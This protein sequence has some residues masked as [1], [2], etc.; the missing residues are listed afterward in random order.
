MPVPI[1]P[2]A[3]RRCGGFSRIVPLLLSSLVL[4]FAPASAATA[5]SVPAGQGVTAQSTT[6]HIAEASRRFAIP[7]SWIRA[8]LRA[9]SAGDMRAVS[10]AGAIGLMQIMPD[11]WAELRLRYGFGGDPFDPRDNILAGAAY[12]RE[13]L[14]RYGNLGAMLAAYNAGPARYDAYLAT[15]HSLPA[16]TRTYVAKLAPILGADGRLDIA[17]AAPATPPDWREAPL[18][19]G[20]PS[21]QG[22]AEAPPLE[23]TSDDSPPGLLLPPNRSSDEPQDGIFLARGSAGDRP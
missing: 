18:F 21:H 22:T 23:R 13:M 3:S 19:V 5:Q 14:D 2:N 12:L 9:E 6:S 17:V 8:V 20:Q 16:E 1:V 4:G 11:T 10:P 7:E 15:G